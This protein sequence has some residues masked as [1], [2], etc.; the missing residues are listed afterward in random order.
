MFFARGLSRLGWASTLTSAALIFVQFQWQPAIVVAVP[1][2]TQCSPPEGRSETCVCQT[3]D[4]VID[5]TG[6]ANYD[7]YSAR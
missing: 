1:T 3:P 2:G 6:L 5:L 7:G 4:G